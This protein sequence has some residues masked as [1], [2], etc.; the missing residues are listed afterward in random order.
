MLCQTD[1]HTTAFLVIKLSSSRDFGALTLSVFA[2]YIN[3]KN[4]SYCELI[5]QRDFIDYN[6]ILLIE[7]PVISNSIS[8]KNILVV[9]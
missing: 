7:S 8:V 6:A 3:N 9:F 2:N 4:S 1:T 5:F